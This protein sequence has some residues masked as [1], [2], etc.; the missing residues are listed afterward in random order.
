L[1]AK[2]ELDVPAP[3]VYVTDTMT[4]QELRRARRQLQMTQRELAQKL[5]LHKNTVARMERDELPVVKTTELAVRFL[6]VTKGG[7]R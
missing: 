5:E 6:L 2:I 7:K 1:I 3:I 4:G